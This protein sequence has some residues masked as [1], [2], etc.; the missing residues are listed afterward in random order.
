MG[1]DGREGRQA[2]G[3][4]KMEK[5]KGEILILRH[6]ERVKTEPQ[7]HFQFSNREDGGITLPDLNTSSTC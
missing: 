7:Q 6:C 2:S 1:G 3:L 5:K 4:I